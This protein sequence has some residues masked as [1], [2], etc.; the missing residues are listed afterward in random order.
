MAKKSKRAFAWAQTVPVDIFRC[1]V[2][3][4]VGRDVDE[5]RKA[6]VCVTRRCRWDG[7]GPSGYFDPVMA[8]CERKGSFK[9]ITVA[10]DGDADKVVWLPEWDEGVFVHECVHAADLILRDKEVE[11]ARGEMRAYLTEHF[12]LKFMEG[13]EKW[14][15]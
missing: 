4:L 9:G 12:Y 10:L 14:R 6:F 8:E 1:G 3:F 15:R 2:C 7:V 5:L 13:K 11:D